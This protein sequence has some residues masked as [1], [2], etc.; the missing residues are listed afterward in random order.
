MINYILQGFG[1]TGWRDFINSSFGHIFSVNFIAVDVIVSAFIGLVHFL[2][3]F[4]HLFLA[5]YVVLILFEWLTGVQA[6]FKRG[7]R[8]ESRKIGRMLL[9]ILTYLVLIYV[10]HTFSANISFPTIGD[11]EFDPFHW[12]YWVVLLAIIWQLVVSL[13]E[14]LGCL[15]FKFARVLLKIINKKFFKMFDLTE[16]TENT[17]T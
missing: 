7:E 11:F 12:L 10:L 2:F 9:K 6:S 5:A 4:N 16:E 13:L 17:N 15:G 14:N 8:H 1:F 3:G